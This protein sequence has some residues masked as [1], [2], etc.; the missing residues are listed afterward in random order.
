[1]KKPLANDVMIEVRDLSVHFDDLYVLK[2]VSFEIKKG[3]FVGLIGP[4]GAGKSTL[5]KTLLG[6]IEPSQGHCTRAPSITMRYVPQHYALSSFAPVSVAEVIQMGSHK[7]A[8]SDMIIKA[9]QSVGL[10]DSYIPKN[11]HTLSGGQKQRVMIAR[12]L[13]EIPDIIFFDE[14]LSGV[15]VKTTSEIHN[16]LKN[17]N[18]DGVTIFFVSHDIDH[19]IDACDIVLCLDQSLHQNCHPVDFAKGQRKEAQSTANK[20]TCVGEIK[21]NLRKQQVHHHHT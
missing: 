6:L 18:L 21:S 2:D 13:I 15:D 12:A 19:V 1:M 20:K 8:P 14:P 5:L 17:L 9:L 4:N 11:Y 7:Y 3:S 10:N 16:L